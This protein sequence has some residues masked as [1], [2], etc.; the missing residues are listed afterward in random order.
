MIEN[1]FIMAENVFIL[2]A[3]TS[4][5][6]G[7]PIM[8]NFLDVAEELCQGESSNS[9]SK[10]FDQI[11]SFISQLQHLNSKIRI[12]VQNIEYLYS[13]LEMAITID[14]LFD[15][16]KAEIITLKD[17]LINLIEYTLQVRIKYPINGELIKPPL[18]LQNFFYIINRIG[19]KKPQ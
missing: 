13:T 5:E 6:A 9:K 8:T 12:D 19:L 16:T 7:A 18:S 3:G 2:G 10:E 17:T 11:F 1:R 15:K 14:K 4:V